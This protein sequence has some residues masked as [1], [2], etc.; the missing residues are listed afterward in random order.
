MTT[1]AGRAAP[2]IL[3]IME[4]AVKVGSC[5]S[6]LPVTPRWE[7]GVITHINTAWSSVNSLT[8]PAQTPA[9]PG[10]PCAGESVIVRETLRCVAPISDVL[11][12]IM[13]V[14]GVM[15]Q[16]TI[17]HPPL[18]LVIITVLETPKLMMANLTQLTDLTRHKSELLSLR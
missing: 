5:P 4:S 14:A 10:S 6:P 12:G 8:T 13:M 2:W 11:L 7:R 3:M 15:L 17:S 16:D 1:A 18:S 9:C